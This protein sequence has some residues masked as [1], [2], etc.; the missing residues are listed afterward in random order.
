MGRKR[1]AATRPGGGP[2]NTPAP[3]ALAAS[4]S[5]PGAVTPPPNVPAGAKGTIVGPTPKDGPTGRGPKAQRGRQQVMGRPNRGW[6]EIAVRRMAP[7]RDIISGRPGGPAPNRDALVRRAPA[8]AE[9]PVAEETVDTTNIA[10]GRA[11]EAERIAA[12]RNNP[13]M[14]NAG[15]PGMPSAPGGTKGGRGV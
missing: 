13:R 12:L 11:A 15:L 4:G 6:K 9:Q 2:T 8:V 14:R 7:N 1:R 3:N 10:A 5:G